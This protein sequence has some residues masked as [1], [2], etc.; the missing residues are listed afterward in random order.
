MDRPDRKG[1]NMKEFCKKNKPIIFIAAIAV[2]AII[3]A[4]IAFSG[5]ADDSIKGTY[6]L[7]D[8]SGTGS[9]MFKTTV[10]DATLEIKADNTGT[11]SMFEQTT[12]VAVNTEDKKISFDGGENYTAYTYEKG[13]LTVEGGGYKAVF[14]KR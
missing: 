8:A 7:V 5:K 14:K 9:E 4:V 10:G 1:A 13:K 6:Q 3:I 12:P 11:L 2:F